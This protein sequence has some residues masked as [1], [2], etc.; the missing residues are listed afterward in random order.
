MVMP[1][2]PARTISAG[3]GEGWGNWAADFLSDVDV[4]HD[5]LRLDYPAAIPSRGVFVYARR[6]A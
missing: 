3:G 4:D 1:A 5:V 2:S 6:E